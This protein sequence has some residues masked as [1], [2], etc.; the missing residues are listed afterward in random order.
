MLSEKTERR[1]EQE[2]DKGAGGGGGKVG[3]EGGREGAEAEIVRLYIGNLLA[4]VKH[5]TTV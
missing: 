2:W 3:Q 1:V 4:C 5:A